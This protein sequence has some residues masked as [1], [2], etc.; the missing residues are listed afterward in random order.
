MAFI[1]DKKNKGDRQRLAQ[2]FFWYTNPDSGAYMMRPVK[3]MTVSNDSVKVE[4]IEV[5]GEGIF[6]FRQA[7]SVV[8]LSERTSG[9]RTEADL[10]IVGNANHPALQRKTVRRV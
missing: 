7:I 10:C 4:R 9:A 2:D 3:T 5:R 6:Q 8:I 1:T